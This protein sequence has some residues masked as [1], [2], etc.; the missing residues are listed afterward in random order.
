M[1]QAGNSNTITR[2][3]LD[4]L[5]IETRYMNSTN[6]D[7]TFTLY[8]ETFASPIM[9]AALSHLTQIAEDV[10]VFVDGMI[11]TGMDAFKA[12]ALGAKGVCIGRPLMAAYTKAKAQGVSEYLKNARDELAK[13]M[14]YTGCTDLGKMDPS[15][16]HVVK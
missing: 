16:I 12:I 4:S 7:T 15:V 14:A 10:P 11:Q 1:A 9:T 2:Y 8:G 3:Y 13:A 6:P 5:L